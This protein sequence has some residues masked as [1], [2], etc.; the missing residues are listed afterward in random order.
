MG[1]GGG[2]GSKRGPRPHR[3]K[4]GKSGGVGEWHC[5]VRWGAR[6]VVVRRAQGAV[7]GCCRRRWGK[8][9]LKETCHHKLSLGKKK[10]LTFTSYR[11][12]LR[13]RPRLTGRVL[14]D[15]GIRRRG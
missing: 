8:E 9:S 10:K 1:E 5:E 6:R 7:G 3:E 11:R 12:S 15:E 4:G 2:E 14:A 13:G